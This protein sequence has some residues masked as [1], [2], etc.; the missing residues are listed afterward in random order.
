MGRSR[1]GLTA[2]IHALCDAGG[3][4]IKLKLSAG[5]AHDGRAADSMLGGL[6][7][8]HILL[9]DAAYDADAMRLNLADRGAW[10]C[11]KPMPTRANIPAFSRFL[12]RFRNTVER[13][14]NKIK[15]FRA[16]ET[17]DEKHG[18][19]LAPHQTRRRQN[20]HAP[21]MSR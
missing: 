14:F 17:R 12:Y 2:K 11:V 5:Q 1:G 20:L 10:A 7:P 6:G 15:H 13:Y 21:F 9:D 4:P 19:F 16:I 3:L 8:G 18:D